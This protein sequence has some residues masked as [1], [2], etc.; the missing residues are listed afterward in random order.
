MAIRITFKRGIRQSQQAARYFSETV[1]GLVEEMVDKLEEHR[2]HIAALQG[3]S[4]QLR[5]W[6]A[7]DLQDGELHD[8]MELLM[9]L[10]SEIR[11]LQDDPGGQ[12]QV[13]QLA[14]GWLH[15]RMGGADLYVEIS[16]KDPDG[17]IHE[18]P[19]L[20]LAIVH[21]RCAMISTDGCL[22]S[23]LDQDM[24]GLTLAGHGSY[25]L[26]VVPNDGRQLRQAS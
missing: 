9:T 5:V 11:M 2:Y 17:G 1:G 10:R 25:L 23:W 22:F 6:S 13:S 14:M 8:L 18:Q 20:A 4:L 7:A 3:P 24:F 16:I 19:E 12:E 21:G 15:E 26:E